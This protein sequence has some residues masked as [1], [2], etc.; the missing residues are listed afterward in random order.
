[1]P[2]AVGAIFY[3]ISNILMGVGLSAMGSAIVSGIITTAAVISGTKL[4]GKV[5]APEIGS[6]AELGQSITSNAPSNTASI[7]VI[8]GRRQVGGTRVFMTTTGDDSKFLHYILAIAE[9]EV[10]QLHN[11]YINNEPLY[12]ADGSINSKFKGGDNNESYIKLNFH[13]GSDT[14]VVDADLAAATTL[15]DE[16][17]TL[18]GVC[19]AYIR[20]EYS[21]D[22]WSSGLPIINFDI[23]GK[24]VRDPRNI[25]NDASGILRFSSNPALIVRDYLTNTR[26]GRSIDTAAI[27]D[28]SFIV[29]ANYCDESI[30][31]NAVA[32]KRYEA[33][34]VLQTSA[35]TISN[36][37]DILTSCRGFLV[38]T[39]GK[40]KIV[41]D[42]VDSS[43]FAFTEDNMIG[44]IALSVASKTSIWNRAKAVFFNKNKQW[45][46]D[47][48]IEDSTSYRT[49][50]NDLL[51]EGTI[52][53]PYTSDHNTAAY[54][55]KQNMNQSRESLMV[56]F[57]STIDSLQ[58]ECGDVV[59]ITSESLGWTT[60]KFRILQISIEAL[61]E[62]TFA[63]R[64][65][66]D[67]VYSI[68]DLTDETFANNTD[69]PDVTT[70]SVPKNIGATETLLFNSPTLI[71]RVTLS[72]TRSVDPYTSKYIVSTKKGNWTTTEQLG[73]TSSNEW[74]VD[75]LESGYY[76]FYVRTVNAAGAES[77]DAN[78]NFEVKGT[79]VLPAV[80]PPAITSVVE[81]LYVTTTGSGVKARATLNF[82]GST[83]NTDWD[84]LGVDIDEYQVQSADLS[85][86]KPTWQSHG[87][88]SGNFF[89][90]NDI[91]PSVYEFRIRAVNDANVKSVWASTVAD[92]VGLTS[93]PS[94]VD[95]FFIRTDSQE[96]HLN[97]DLV[98]DADVNIGGNYEV[99]HSDLTTGAT[100]AD[101]RI[102]I[103]YVSGIQNAVTL[104]LL[105]GTYLI[106][107]VDSTGHKSDNATL[108]VNSISPSLF[109]KH[110]YTI[111]TESNSATSWAG[112]K[113]NLI[114]DS[115][116]NVLKFES[117]IYF[118][119]VT[120][121][122]D[123]WA[124]FD[125][126]GN[127]F[128]TGTY[129]F[130]DYID[131]G[132][133]ASLGLSSTLTFTTTDISGLFD[134]RTEYI[135]NWQSFESLDDFDDVK[136]KLYY[137]STT[138][139]PASSPTW[140][141]WQEL[142]TGTVY[143]RGFKMKMIATTGDSSHQIAISQ[144]QARLEAWFRLNADRLTSSTS[145]FAV[146]F[147][148]AFKGT[149]TVAIA[150][151]NMST[152]DYYSLSS[153]ANTGFTVQFFNSSGTGVA[154]TFD[155]LARGY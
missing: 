90:F 31:L 115:T 136:I 141:S 41:L 86:H 128:T 150:A 1:M 142:T 16:T 49:S 77:D 50:D 24:K 95:N 82:V 135:D 114:V 80:N 62:I 113:T 147:D 120:D 70:V 38:Y 151:Q 17:C 110:T 65:Y 105:V 131:F 123:D 119:S 117:S 61:D 26:Y 33:N 44:D 104:P 69:L 15:W 67:D 22:I 71:N 140:G 75:N 9:G 6:M 11:V 60:K 99:R 138:D 106:K 148:D 83:G 23:S 3:H 108:V 68:E 66:N 121:D 25:A 63:A 73:T 48:A 155:Y 118:D 145:A 78:I 2:Q 58:V 98:S 53:L 10:S 87:T 59:T 8:Y 45:T 57:R 88:T 127:L 79:S 154:R 134:T 94:D 55:A 122:I 74:I 124:L 42:K 81:S 92:I 34:G 96:A 13:T 93:P 32:Q 102:L 37:N 36:L 18:S 149:P 29:A 103:D 85:Y 84:A 7:P 112:T 132:L 51:L 125:S 137:A 21:T 89:E 126:L 153:I 116:T 152:G 12:N 30:T 39:G 52:E 4:L 14:Q 111:Q 56:T 143:G 47:Y 64:E 129:E 109:D 101:S 5:L 107:A 46:A 91:D 40:Y 72:W 130:T 27:D 19:Y 97:W 144:I 76:T 43:T 100:W 133:S 139:N 28:T 20:L 35:A 54:I 146:T